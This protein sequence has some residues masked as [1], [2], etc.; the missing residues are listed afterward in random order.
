MTEQKILYL[1]RADI[2]KVNLPMKKIIGL[3]EDAFC[4]KGNGYIISDRKF[5]MEAKDGAVIKKQVDVD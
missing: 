2:E 4:E 5:L 1:S 3:L